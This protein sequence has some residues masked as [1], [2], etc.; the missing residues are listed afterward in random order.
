MARFVGILAFLVFVIGFTFVGK[1]LWELYGTDYV[2]DKV[3]SNTVKVIE[4]QKPLLITKEIPAPK[5]HEAFAVIRSPK[6]GS[7]RPIIEG[8]GTTDLQKGVGH[9]VGTAFPGQSGNFSVAGHRTTY[10]KP[11]RNVDKLRKGDLITVDTPYMTVVYSV[12]G[13]RIVTPDD[14]KV[15]DATKDATMT[16]TSCEPVFSA[17]KRYVVFAKM[18]SKVDKHA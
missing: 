14:V 7:P 9:Y 5:H 4:Q 13:H 15:L 2:A 16:L 17:T 12:T 1:S 3:Q 10:G 18:I 8:T 11:F 6:L